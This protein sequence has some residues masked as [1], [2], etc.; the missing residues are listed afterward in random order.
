MT[1]LI[2]FGAGQSV[3]GVWTSDWT[4]GH[5]GYVESY[6]PA[7]NTITVSQGG[8]GFSSPGGPNLQT[9][10]ASGYTYIHR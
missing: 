8:M 10:N 1:Y 3:G 4:Y 9:M 5:V 7:T 2:V 6:D